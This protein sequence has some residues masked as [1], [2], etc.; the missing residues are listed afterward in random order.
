MFK[1]LF[2][3]F[4][5]L[6]AVSIPAL[7]GNWITPIA[8]NAI[9]FPNA[10][11]MGVSISTGSITGHYIK[12]GSTLLYDIY[13]VKDSTGTKG[14]ITLRDYAG[15]TIV[16]ALGVSTNLLNT[17]SSYSV[18]PLAKAGIPIRLATGL[19]ITVSGVTPTGGTIKFYAL[20]R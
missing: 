19:K 6:L 5:L 15:S 3:I 16:L 2:V 20:Y 12:N 1:K 18:L 11:L 4:T 8:D 14:T 13:I 17:E 10:N 9:P 7:A